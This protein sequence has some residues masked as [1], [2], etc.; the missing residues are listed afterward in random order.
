[1]KN[2]NSGKYGVIFFLIL[3]VLVMAVIKIKY[4][5]RGGEITPPPTS[6][7]PTETITATPTESTS[8]ATIMQVDETKYPLWAELPYLG[9]GFTV[10]KYTAPKVLLVQL[11]GVATQSATKAINVWLGTFGNA[12]KGHKIEFTNQN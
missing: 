3:V 9:T 12:G 8:G 7:V 5:Y 2:E 11:E 6:P 1:M 10:E 4:G